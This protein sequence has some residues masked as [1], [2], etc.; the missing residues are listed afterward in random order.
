[1]LPYLKDH[2]C[3]TLSELIDTIKNSQKWMLF[4]RG[5]TQLFFQKTNI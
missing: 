2:R 3:K 4:L 5:V 1:M